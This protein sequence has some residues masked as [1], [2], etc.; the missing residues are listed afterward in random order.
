MGYTCEA[1]HGIHQR[2]RREERLVAAQVSDRMGLDCD[3]LPR[4]F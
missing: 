4:G 2:Q 3:G 1:S